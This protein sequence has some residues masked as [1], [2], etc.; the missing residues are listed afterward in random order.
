MKIPYQGQGGGGYND[1]VST[2]GSQENTAWLRQEV[3]RYY[4]EIME[5][6]GLS[7][8]SIDFNNFTKD[9]DGRL[10]VKVVINGIIT[11]KSLYANSGMLFAISTL[12]GQGGTALL[13]SLGLYTKLSQRAS[14]A[15]SSLDFEISR[16]DA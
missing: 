4:K 10:A 16:L 9:S 8:G 7:P 14:A 6:D 2:V 3:N 13:R 1:T 12:R 11:T 5:R 15:L